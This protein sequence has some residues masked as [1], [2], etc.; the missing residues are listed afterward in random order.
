[1]GAVKLTAKGNLKRFKEL[2]E[3]RGTETGAWRG[4]VA[5]H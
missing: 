3:A 5:P 4:S 2:V 1:V